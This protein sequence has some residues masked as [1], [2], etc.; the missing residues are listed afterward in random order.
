MYWGK[1]GQQSNPSVSRPALFV[2]KDPSDACHLI[3][4]FEM[5][6]QTASNQEYLDPGRIS[7]GV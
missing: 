2:Q 6:S 3:F 1:N 7:G 4:E 5:P